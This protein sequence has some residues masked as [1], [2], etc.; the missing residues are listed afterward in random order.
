VYIYNNITHFSGLTP[1]L[2]LVIVKAK[3]EQL[4]SKLRLMFTV[5]LICQYL[6]FI[7]PRKKKANN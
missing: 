1:S 3:S 4:T 5:N 7:A 6:I 2:L